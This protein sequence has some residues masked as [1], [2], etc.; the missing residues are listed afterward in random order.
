VLTLISL[1]FF[2][3][4]SETAL[5]LMTFLVVLLDRNFDLPALGW[6]VQP[7]VAVITYRLVVDPGFF[8]AADFDFTLEQPASITQVVLAYSGTLILLAGALRIG[9][10]NRAKTVLILESDIWTI[11]GVFICVLIFRAVSEAILCSHWSVGLLATVWAASFV[12]QLD[13]MQASNRFT[14][15]LRGGPAIVFAPIVLALLAV[16]F[17]LSNPLNN[18]SELVGGP[19]IL[20]TL[21]VAYLPLAVVFTVAAWKLAHFGRRVRMVFTVSASSMAAWYVTLEIR[22]LWRGNDL[23]VPGVTDPELYSYTLALLITSVVILLLAFS[24]RALVLRK[25]AMAG[26]A[27]TIAKVFLV[28]TSGPSGLARVFSF[29]GLGLT[30]VALAWPNRVI[31]AQWN[32]GGAG[33]ARPAPR[34]VLTTTDFGH[35]QPD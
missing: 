31:T 20:D 14:L 18:R 34:S 26:V 12:N 30:L 32:L 4:L 13:R 29:L 24:R 6:F 16:L 5:A 35:V 22:H 28:D 19:T 21:S 9:R 10:D 27:V 23:S 3:L 7:G 33:C 2:L 25:L 17:G 11:A 15:V 8:W 1:A